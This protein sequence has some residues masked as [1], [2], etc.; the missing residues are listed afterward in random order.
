MTQS[1]HTTARLLGW[2]E[3][4]DP[5]D[6]CDDSV[7]AEW[8]RASATGRD[9]DYAAA[10]AE[11]D[12][13]LA[14]VPVDSELHRRLEC[15]RTAYAPILGEPVSRERLRGHLNASRS[16]AVRHFAAYQ[17]ARDFELERNWRKA[18]FYG[19]Q[20]LN[21]AVSME[22]PSWQAAAHN[23]LG[24]ALTGCSRFEEAQEHYRLALECEPEFPLWVAQIED[25]LGYVATVREDYSRA[26][27][28]LASALW[29]LR[30]DQVTT[31]RLSLELDLCFFYLQ[32]GA[33]HRAARH[34]EQALLLART[35][36]DGSGQLS[37]ALF[38][39]AEAAKRTDQL[40]QARRHAREL[41]ELKGYPE[42]ADA[43]L[44]IDALEVVNLKC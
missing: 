6:R 1:V 5:L 8:E 27:S 20:S 2:A 12:R 33:D 16:Q 9:G 22:R 34:G 42:M 25:N 7:R 35:H 30:S 19:D 23:L 44:G 26:R 24:N 18:L 4:Y 10:A 21:A 15:G 43:L 37:N 28:H 31:A 38:L 14:S 17:L 41:A 39:C 40:F 13:I 32:T 29:K 36:D 11:M 3:A